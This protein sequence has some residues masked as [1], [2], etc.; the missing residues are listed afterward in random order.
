MWA[1]F[2]PRCVLSR[3][4]KLHVLDVSRFCP[5]LERRIFVGETSFCQSNVQVEVAIGAGGGRTG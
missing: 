3:K 1:L 2:L 5:L 4:K